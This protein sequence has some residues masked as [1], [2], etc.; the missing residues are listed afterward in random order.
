MRTLCWIHAGIR[1]CSNS[2]LPGF[3]V[4][5]R[6]GHHWWTQLRVTL[7][8]HWPAKVLKFLIGEPFKAIVAPTTAGRMYEL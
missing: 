4:Q 7:K 6:M 1:I 5:I 8:N 3:F 2:A